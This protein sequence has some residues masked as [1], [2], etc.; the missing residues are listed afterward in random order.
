M[1]AKDEPAVLDEPTTDAAAQTQPT[2]QATAAAGE[3]PE[4]AVPPEDEPDE[5]HEPT[6]DEPAH[7]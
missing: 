7:A 5:L 3:R 6:K 2:G 4:C 1:M